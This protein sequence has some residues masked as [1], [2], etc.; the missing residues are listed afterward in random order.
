MLLYIVSIFNKMLI[1]PFLIVIIVMM[2]C[3]IFDSSV[4]NLTYSE[5][6]LLSHIC[7][8]NL[9]AISKCLGHIF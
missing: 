6:Q 4:L 1:K 2:T 3:C 8:P 5:Q 7:K 9:S